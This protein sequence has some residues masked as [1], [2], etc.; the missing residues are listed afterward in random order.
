MQNRAPAEVT[1]HF[2]DLMARTRD[3]AAF[4]RSVQEYVRIMEKDGYSLRRG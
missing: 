4:L 3:N 1:E 2:I